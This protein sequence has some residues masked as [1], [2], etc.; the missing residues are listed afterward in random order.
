MSASEPDSTPPDSTDGAPDE[1]PTQANEPAAEEPTAVH[2]PA[3]AAHEPAVPAPSKGRRWAVRIILFLAVIIGVVATLAVWVNRQALNAENWANTSSSLLENKQIRAQLATYIVDEVYANVDVSG[4]IESVVPK[5][6]KPLAGPAA[7]ALRGAAEDGVST[8]LEQP[9]I[10]SAW[11]ASNRAAMQQLVNVI[12]E[13]KQGVVNYSHGK[14]TISI[15]PIVQEAV[16]RLGLPKDLANK[17]PAGAGEFT[18]LQS[19]D[20][21]AVQSYGKALRG[22]AI[23]LPILTLLLFL[24]AVWL[25]RGRRRQT[26]L[27]VGIDLIV[28]GAI[29]LVARTVADR[30]AVGS[31]ASTDALRPAVEAALI[32]ATHMLKEI[33]WSLVITG[34][35]IIAAALLAGPTRPAVATRRFLS[36]WLRDYR[37]VVYGVLGVVGVLIIV[38]EPVPWT[39]Q[40]LP[41]LLALVLVVVGVELLR[42]QTNREFPGTSA[43]DV[44]DTLQSWFDRARGKMQTGTA[45][46]SAS[47]T[48]R[49]EQRATASEARTAVV[50]P[51][52]APAEAVTEVVPAPAAPAPPAPAPAGEDD[53]IARLERLAALHEK[54]VLTDDELAA[55]KRKVLGS[56]T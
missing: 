48:A 10:Q 34:L 36:P 40:P 14:V 41:L 9:L 21:A 17:I 25:A 3:T 54:G 51:A 43:S 52:P 16:D 6:L 4:E 18:V 2:E 49:R 27:L 26:L 45:A 8:L 20:V 23:V 56:G 30:Q 22:L 29:V 7:G 13:K 15:R 32:I 47:V 42:R 5:D 55:E 19:D 33:A 53:H 35:P 39:S 44:T 50:P 38:W 24:L 46:V 28:I 37:G 1:A 31:L 12:E 11:K